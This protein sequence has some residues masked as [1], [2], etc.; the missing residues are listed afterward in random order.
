VVDKTG[1]TSMSNSSDAFSA[2]GRY[3]RITVTGSSQAGGYPSFYEC[4]VYGASTPA[5]SLVPATLLATTSGN[6]LALS[7]PTDHL[8]WHLQIQTNVAGPGLGNW[9]T[10]PGS[11]LVTST[12]MTMI[13]SNGPVFYRLVYP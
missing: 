12:N 8:G 6:A 3:V 11:D 4:V 13:R 2:V 10:V 7:W 5:I 1:N 9:L